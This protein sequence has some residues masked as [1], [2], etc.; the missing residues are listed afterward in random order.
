MTDSVHPASPDAAGSAGGAVPSTP[1]SADRAPPPVPAE[2]G[3]AELDAHGFNPADYHWVPMPR[4]RRADGWSA[5]R[6][7]RFIETLADTGLVAEA[8]REVGMSVQSCYRLRRSPGAE[9]FARAWAAAIEQASQALLDLT[10]ERV[11]SGEEVPIL[12]RDGQRIGSRRRYSERMT[13]FMLRAYFPERFGRRNDAA[14]TARTSD[15]SAPPA[16]PIADALAALDPA[17][18]DE[19]HR[20]MAPGALS[21]LIANE[22]E[23]ERF[24]AEYPDAAAREAA[25]DAELE[26]MP[27]EPPPHDWDPFIPATGQAR[28]DARPP[29]PPVHDWVSELRLRTQAEDEIAN[30]A[31]TRGRR[32]GKTRDPL[33]FD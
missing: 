18:P 33:T 9:G 2:P 27:L 25:R 21:D 1:L 22:R 31:R 17:L 8:A 7:R 5:E 10:F 16:P 30:A 6:Q 14:V 11:I 28:L 15:A 23:A 19:P 29:E 32:R 13:M 20:L 12:A 24:A 26:A 3:Q 4:R